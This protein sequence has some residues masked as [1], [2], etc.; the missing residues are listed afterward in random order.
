MRTTFLRTFVSVALLGL[1]L[2]AGCSAGT[3][4]EPAA[5][6][7]P[8]ATVNEQE[9]APM[10]ES[11]T[12]A[13]SESE[14]ATFGAGCFWCVEAVLEQLDGVSDVSSG[15]MGGHVENPTYRQICTG[16]TGHAEVVQVTFDPSRISYDQ[17]LDWFWKL[18]DPTTLNRQGPDRGTQYRSAIF[19]HSDA[20]RAAAERSRDAA[21]ASGDFSGPIVTEITEAGVFYEAEAYHQDYYQAN[22]DAPYCR[23]QIT[24]KLKKLGLDE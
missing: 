16:S 12:P 19:F 18:H 15:Y 10:A 8:P 3:A 20:Q 9:S 4:R 17:L 24:P 23:V 7:P 21:D 22:K 1:T 11:P 2:L 13:A 6:E 5:P 14:T